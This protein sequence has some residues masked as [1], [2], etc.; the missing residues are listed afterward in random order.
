MGLL[1]VEINRTSGTV[2]AIARP[3][4]WPGARTISSSAA[5]LTKWPSSWAIWK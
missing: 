1:T 5:G 3:P 2:R 4:P